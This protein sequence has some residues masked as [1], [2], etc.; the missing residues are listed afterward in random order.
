MYSF[1]MQATNSLKRVYFT[2]IIIKNI[3]YYK[4]F[5][6]TKKISQCF[7][8][9][10]HFLQINCQDCSPPPFRETERLSVGDMRALILKGNPCG[11]TELTCGHRGLR[12]DM[13][14]QALGTAT[15]RKWL[16][17]S[18]PGWGPEPRSSFSQLC[19]CCVNMCVRV[20]TCVCV[21]VCEY[22][23]LVVCVCVLTTRQTWEKQRERERESTSIQSQ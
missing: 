19:M 18:S 5:H 17:Q 7:Y 16:F 14:S 21:C 22:A 20:C 23:H 3:I 8:I 12:S 9:F 6:L 15:E 11:R 4:L 13:K 1:S 2:F 10:S